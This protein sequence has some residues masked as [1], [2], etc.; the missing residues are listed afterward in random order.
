MTRCD[1]AH[2]PAVVAGRMTSCMLYALLLLLLLLM[3]MMMMMLVTRWR[4]E[5]N[6][7][8]QHRRA[9]TVGAGRMDSKYA[10]EASTR[11][12]CWASHVARYPRPARRP[13][14]GRDPMTPITH[15]SRCNCASCV[16][17]IGTRPDR[18]DPGHPDRSSPCPRL[19]YTEP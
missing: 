7:L 5:S 12:P 6:A 18:P 15:A 8:Q 9:R 13:T 11:C 1:T 16:V 3:M 2:A 14:A 17:V 19:T 10:V 4:C